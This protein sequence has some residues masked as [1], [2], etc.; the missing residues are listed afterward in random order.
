M[1][2]ACRRRLQRK[3]S[4][5]LFVF[6][7]ISSEHRAGANWLKPEATRSFSGVFLTRDHGGTVRHA[8]ETI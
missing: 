2:M 4:F 5:D 1:R 6:R 8:V 7:Q 3:L